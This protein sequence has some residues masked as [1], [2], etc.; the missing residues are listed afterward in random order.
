[1]TI[2][3]KICGLRDE[4]DIDTSIKYGA[5]YIG[6]VFF[7]PSPRN[8]SID[9]GKHL[10]RH[11]AG[12]AKV[13]ALTVDAQDKA[14]MQIVNEVQ[15]DIF[16]LHGSESVERIHRVSDL[17]GC[18]IIKVVKVRTSEDAKN[19]FVYKNA[20][21]YILFDAK[22]NSG[23]I[24][25]GGNGKPF[26]WDALEKITLDTNYFLAGGLTPENVGRAIQLTNAQIVDVSSGVEVSPGC[27]DPVLIRA[28]L[29]AAKGL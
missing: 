3:V 7:T 21:R 5:D 14:I 28:F 8:I 25:P 1:M 26:N 17:T 12:R 15:P 29:K 4:A 16:Q 10:V 13:V 22:P 24:L 20:A 27:K 2:K 19:A 11:I 18:D 6:L 23:S 9:R